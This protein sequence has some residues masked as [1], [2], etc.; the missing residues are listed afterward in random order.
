MKR[1][2]LRWVGVALLWALPASASVLNVPQRVV[3]N[4]EVWWTVI[5]PATATGV[6]VHGLTPGGGTSAYAADA[7]CVPYLGNRYCTVPGFRRSQL[8]YGGSVEIRDCN[9]GICGP[10]VQELNLKCA[11]IASPVATGC[12]CDALAREPLGSLCEYP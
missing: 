4:G 12:P 8:Q 10:W 1:L 5:V 11:I 3:L 6:M 7:Y 9:G 2:I